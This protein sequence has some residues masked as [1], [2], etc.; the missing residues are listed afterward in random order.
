MAVAAW[1]ASTAFS[2]GDVRRATTTQASG[3]WFECIVAGTSGS[4]EPDWPQS[5]FKIDS[6]VNLNDADEV[7]ANCLITFNNQC[8]SAGVVVDGTVTWK[9][10]A[11]TFDDLASL[12]PSAIIEL[13]ELKLDSTLHGS[14]TVYRF[15]AGS[16]E[17]VDSNIVFNGET[18]TRLPVKADGFEYTNT[19]TLPRPTL[20][21]SNLDG[22]M[23]TILL[24][25][26]A[27]T[28]GNDL[29]GAEVKRIR[30]LRKYLD[31]ANFVTPN[32]LITQ[33][34]DQLVT[35]SG[36]NILAVSGFAPSADPN[37]KFPDEI[38][39]IDRKANESRDSVTFEL[40]SKFDLAGQKLPKR[41]IIA[42]V[43]QWRYRS[44]ECTYAGSNYFDVNGRSV[45]T[46][47][48]DVCGKRVESCKL[49]FGDNAELPFGSFPG[50]GL[51]K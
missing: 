1:A 12:N 15:H 39:Y 27:T 17:K 49:R 4:S 14:S 9:A 13:F 26:N 21:I 51:T 8:V 40:A 43:C 47:A 20:T 38:W 48:A 7:A 5:L 6:T 24:L 29:G 3:F 34:G 28:A 16:N 10:I 23:T 32:F 11:S 18:Y 33:G 45:T 46:L 36:D 25:I 22:N 41:Q 50:A 35:Q 19:G 2:V 37:A 31:A 42:N 30:T 44:E